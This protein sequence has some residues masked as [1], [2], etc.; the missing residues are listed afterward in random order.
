MIGKPLA[1]LALRADAVPLPRLARLAPGATVAR[2]A[3]FVM[4]GGQPFSPP[5]A[6][7]GGEVD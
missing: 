3:S 4:H 7:E 6:S 1:V 2:T 5:A